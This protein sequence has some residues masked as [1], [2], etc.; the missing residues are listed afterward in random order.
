MI[1]QL[2][3]ETSNDCELPGNGNS[4]YA[5]RINI[6]EKSECVVE[7]SQHYIV[8]VV[9]LDCRSCVVTVACIKLHFTYCSCQVEALCCRLIIL[10]II[11]EVVL[12]HFKWSWSY[13]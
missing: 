11:I 1:S 13:S 9:D 2:T 7:W 5:G 6:N 12:R 4:S 3:L 8:S 10:R